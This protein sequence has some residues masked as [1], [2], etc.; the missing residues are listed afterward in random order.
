M[1]FR[2][3]VVDKK[4]VEVDKSVVVLREASDVTLGYSLF[5]LELKCIITKIITAKD[6]ISIQ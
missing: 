5:F 4:A 1:V 6:I 2:E 3:K